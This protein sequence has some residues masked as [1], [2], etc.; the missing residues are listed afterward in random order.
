MNEKLE[1]TESQTPENADVEVTDKPID[2]TVNEAT[3]ESIEAGDESENIEEQKPAEKKKRSFMPWLLLI[4]IIAALGGLAAKGQLIPLYQ[5]VSGWVSGLTA[6][7]PASTPP[8]KLATSEEVQL[9]LSKVEALQTEL[10][11]K[12]PSLPPEEMAETLRTELGDVAKAIEV[13]HN[14]TLSNLTTE[15]NQVAEEQKVLRTSLHAQQQV[16]L[17]VRLRWINNP[18]SR[19]PQIKLAWEEITLLAG[20]SAEQHAKAEEMQN[21]ARD[22]I[23]EVLQWQASLQKWADTLE[24]PTHKN[25]V[26]TLAHPWLDWAAGQFHLRRT[27]SKDSRQ[28]IRLKNKIEGMINQMTAENWPAESDWQAL[29]AELVLQARSKQAKD[30]TEPVELH[31]PRSFK[32]IQSDIDTLQQTAQQWLEQTS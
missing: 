27:P 25:I 23:Q 21:L 12:P 29:R 8:P 15:L 30:N 2:E 10:Q 24:V 14:E 1:D 17:Q 31:L 19:L 11:S 26:P 9:L 22:T 16:N 3:D 5:S 7:K 4:L 6:Q 13:L 20:L 32:A 18:A 28:L